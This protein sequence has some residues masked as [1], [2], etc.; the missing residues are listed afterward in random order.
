MWKNKLKRDV[1]VLAP[2][3]E[4]SARLRDKLVAWYAKGRAKTVLVDLVSCAT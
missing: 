1:A 4:Y 3:I 2:R